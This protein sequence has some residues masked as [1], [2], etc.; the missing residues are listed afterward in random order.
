LSDR[1][2][3]GLS[4][5]VLTYNRKDL[6]RG[7]LE[8]LFQQSDPGVPL[9]IVV[10]DDGSTDG[11]RAMVDELRAERPRV[12]YRFQDHQGIPAARNTGI[13]S[14]SG[15]IVAIVADDYLL[16]PDYAKTIISFFRKEPSAKVVRFKIVSAGDDFVSRVSHAY[17]EASIKRRLSEGA[18]PDGCQ[19]LWKEFNTEERH[20][21]DH[22]LEAAGAAA[23][24]RE[25]FDEVG[26]FDESFLRAEDTEFTRRLRMKGILVHYVPI[27]L[28]RH[29]YSSNLAASVKTCFES[30]RFRWHYYA[31]YSEDPVNLRELVS[32]G[33]K[34]KSLALC[35]ALRRT[36]QPG[37]LGRSFLYLPFMFLFEASNKAGFFCEWISRRRRKSLPSGRTGCAR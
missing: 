29:R 1:A 37:S 33:V 19:H 35:W 20:T 25:V 13:R 21:V 34:V 36:G 18:T 4:I 24:A 26:L 16:A 7:C 14:A 22:G 27:P 5:V 30:G 12:E 17:R 3:G 23:I 10:V 2:H 28:I 31:K 11:T 32:Q 6:L 15:D 9:E 8:S